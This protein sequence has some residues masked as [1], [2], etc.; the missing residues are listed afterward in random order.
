MDGNGQIFQYFKSS[1]LYIWDNF[2]EPFLRTTALSSVASHMSIAQK[3]CGVL[4][5]DLGNRDEEAA[6][7]RLLAWRWFK[8]D[9]TTRPWNGKISM[10]EIC[11]K[12][13]LWP[14]A[15]TGCIY[16]GLQQGIFFSN[17]Q[18]MEV[19]SRHWTTLESSGLGLPG[20][21]NHLLA[22]TSNKKSGNWKGL[23]DFTQII[24]NFSVRGGSRCQLSF[25][26]LGLN[27]SR[28]GFQMH[29][30]A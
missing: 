17:W 24:S 16:N 18:V 19:D 22:K 26:E 20:Q 7:N 5:R 1:K 3:R 2:L 4:L 30:S 29:L 28:F 6:G 23:P 10:L 13:Y 14:V 8:D 12:V 15:W 11:G 25:E 21:M 9:D 27:F